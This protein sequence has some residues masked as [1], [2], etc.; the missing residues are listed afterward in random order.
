MKKKSN[1]GN[2]RRKFLSMGLLG[3]AALITQNAAAM[4]SPESEEETVSMLTPDGKLVQ[5]KKNVLEST[6]ERQKAGNKDILDWRTTQ[7]KK[8]Q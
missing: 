3:G 2:P 6:T 8:E 7:N 1:H 4:V 5:V